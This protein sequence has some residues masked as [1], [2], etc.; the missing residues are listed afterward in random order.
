MVGRVDLAVVVAAAPQ[1]AQLIVGEVLDEL[2]EP[3]IRPEEVLADVCPVGDRHA[4]RFAVGRLGHFVHE[5][6]VDVARKEIVPLPRPEHLD[7][8]PARPAED[9][10]ELLDDLSVAANRSVEALQVAVH[11]EREV[12]ESLAGRDVQ[13]PKRLGLVALAVAD[14]RPHARCGRVLDAA[15]LQVAV[16]ARLVDRR[17]RTKAHRNSREL[18][19]LRHEPRV[20]V[21]RE[22]LA[23][24]DL[25]AKVV[26]L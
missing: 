18:P 17:E 2:A 1:A 22:P 7:D 26:E 5:H 3:R 25:A 15:V 9:R 8:V 21:A 19:E 13:R 20:R 16:E 14:E 23:G 12:V 10:F 4:L 6:A 24:N 11:D